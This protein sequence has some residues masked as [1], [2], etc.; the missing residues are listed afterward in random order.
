MLTVRRSLILCIGA[1]AVL[2]DMDARMRKRVRMLQT[3]QTVQSG[4]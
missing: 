1:Q 4:G 2:K 3:E